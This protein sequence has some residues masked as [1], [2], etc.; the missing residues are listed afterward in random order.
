M[1]LALLANAELSVGI[2]GERRVIRLI[3]E[4]VKGSSEPC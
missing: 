2:G 1:T 3:R 4:N